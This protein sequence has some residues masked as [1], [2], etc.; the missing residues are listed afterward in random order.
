M[1]V[2]KNS[3]L[4]EINKFNYLRGQLTGKALITISGFSLSTE[5]YKEA[6]K[7]LKECYA[8]PQLIISNHMAKLLGLNTFNDSN[9]ITKLR[10]LYDQIE[11]NI[12]SLDVLGIK[13]EQ[14][15]LL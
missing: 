2:D 5:N 9:D 4:S 13:P 3:Q 12:R 8:N 7:L 14:F 10:A 1:V 15:G 11:T 6:I